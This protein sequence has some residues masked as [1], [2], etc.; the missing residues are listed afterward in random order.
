MV[1]EIENLYLSLYMYDKMKLFLSIGCFETNLAMPCGVCVG[2]QSVGESCGTKKII[3]TPKLVSNA[4][5]NT[6]IN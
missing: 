3:L 2:W 6:I 4:I 5:T 1:L